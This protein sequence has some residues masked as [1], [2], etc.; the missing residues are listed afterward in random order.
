MPR[1]KGDPAE[2]FLAAYPPAVARL[3]LATRA[4]VLAALP[5]VAETVDRPARMLAYGYGPGYGGMICTLIPSQKGVK[6]GLY[7]GS[8][9]SDPD[10]L[11]EGIRQG[12]PPRA[13]PRRRRAAPGRDRT[14]AESR[15]MRPGRGVRA[16]GPPGS[17]PVQP[18]L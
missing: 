9:L 3:V 2:T 6:L 17:R 10:G 11:L 4:R 13:D 14:A 16:D 8:E 15:A 12:P 7:R 1:A 18:G 5:E